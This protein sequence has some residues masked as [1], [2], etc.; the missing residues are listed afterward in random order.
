MKSLEELYSEAEKLAGR[1]VEVDRTAKGEY[2]VAWFNINTTPP[3]V[4][5]GEAE[6]LEKFIEK[7]SAE[8]L[9]SDSETATLPD[10]NNA[11]EETDGIN[12]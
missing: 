11:Q 1:P 5:F 4:C 7:L 3:P 6:A 9:Q 8:K 12:T 2:I 10:V